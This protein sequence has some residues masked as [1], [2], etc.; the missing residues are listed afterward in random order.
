M[1]TL[2][3]RERPDP[4][5]IALC[6]PDDVQEPP[7]ANS[8]AH[9]SAVRRFFIIGALAAARRFSNDDRF[10]GNRRIGL[11]KTEDTQL[12]AIDAA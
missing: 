11:A 5:P 9:A 4:P 12:Y 8:L 3:G 2:P 1:R 10:S 6:S 7:F